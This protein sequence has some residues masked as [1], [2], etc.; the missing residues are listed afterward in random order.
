MVVFSS[1]SSFSPFKRVERDSRFLVRRL[2]LF[3]GAS[4]ALPNLRFFFSTLSS[5][6]RGKVV[7]HSPSSYPR[8]DQNT[9]LGLS[10]STSSSHRDAGAISFHS[11][12]VRRG[13]CIH[14]SNSFLLRKGTRQ[15]SSSLLSS[16]LAFCPSDSHI[17]VPFQKPELSFPENRLVHVCQESSLGPS[18]STSSSSRLLAGN[19]L[20]RQRFDRRGEREEAKHSSYQK[21]HASSSSSSSSR[22]CSSLYSLPFFSLLGGTN[23]LNAPS[24]HHAALKGREGEE[25]SVQASPSTRLALRLSS[26]SFASTTAST[27]HPLRSTSSSSSSSSS[28]EEISSPSSLHSSS[29]GGS[30][31]FT[32]EKEEKE[33]LSKINEELIAK[34]DGEEREKDA[35]VKEEGERARSIQHTGVVN[36]PKDSR[37]QGEEKARREKVDAEQHLGSSSSSS[38]SSS[39]SSSPPTAGL[40]DEVKKKE[41]ASFSE[42]KKKEERKEKSSPQE[43]QASH[44][45]GGSSQKGEKFFTLFTFAILFSGL[46]Y[47]GL[48]IVRLA[49]LGNKSF[50]GMSRKYSRRKGYVLSL[51]LLFHRSSPPPH[52]FFLFSI[53]YLRLL[54]L[55][56]PCWRAHHR[57]FLHLQPGFLHLARE[58]V[59]LLTLFLSLVHVCL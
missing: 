7:F 58:E 29:P 2:F 45:E 26:C 14:G 35:G 1:S 52:S 10:S 43:S 39:T 54:S 49:N 32:R 21:H 47:E 3:P 13:L 31:D 48:R 51:V 59:R 34:R 38:I 30:L 57:S 33:R 41:E 24:V 40:S 44:H 9:L 23:A 4:H 16:T 17:S 56:I 25:K 18:I 6:P 37:A 46:A 27:S 11:S 12:C 8:S 19:I 42:E 20:R 22:H 28:N 55:L 53:L 36:N 5:S 50:Q 15:S